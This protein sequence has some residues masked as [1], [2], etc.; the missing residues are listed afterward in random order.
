MMKNNLGVLE[1][2]KQF[3]VVKLGHEQ[4]GID[5][6]YV[7]NIV[8]MTKITRVPKAKKYIKGVINLRGEIVPV[9]SM[10]IKFT[11]DEIEYNND[12]RIIIIKVDNQSMGLIVDE[13][14]EVIQL[15]EKAIQTKVNESNEEKSSYIS[16]IGKIQ[17]DELVTL[18]NLQ[19]VIEEN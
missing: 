18:L 9:M 2:I 1:E 12:T 17:G 7:Q 8:R 5:I 13:V 10:R 14:K 19:G 3:I 15:T 16:G 11:L 6:T 4:Y